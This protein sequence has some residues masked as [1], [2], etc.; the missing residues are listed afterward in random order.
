MVFTA[1]NMFKLAV[2]TASSP[3]ARISQSLS[4]TVG[5]SIVRREPISFSANAWKYLNA[6]FLIML[7]NQSRRRVDLLDLS[8]HFIGECARSDNDRGRLQ[9]SQD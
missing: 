6:D 9:T 5:A 1:L 2:M 3:S 8:D 4:E 7:E